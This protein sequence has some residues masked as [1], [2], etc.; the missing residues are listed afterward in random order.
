MQELSG[1]PGLSLA[2]NT[3][4]GP[5]G[6]RGRQRAVLRE[7]VYA[8]NL[9]LFV[10]ITENDVF[11]LK[12]LHDKQSMAVLSGWQHELAHIGGFSPVVV[13]GDIDAPDPINPEVTRAV[14]SIGIVT[15]HDG[16]SLAP[17]EIIAPPV[18]TD[19]AQPNFHNNYQDPEAFLAAGGRRGR[20]YVPLTDGTYFIN[21]WFATVEMI[22]KTVVPI[23]YVGVVVSYYGRLGTRP[24]GRGVPSR[25]TR[26][27]RRARR[28]GKCPG[29][30]QIRVQHVRRQHHPGADHELRAAL[31]HRPDRDRTAT[32][33]ACGRSTW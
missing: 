33:K 8:I 26:G 1:R 11:L 5:R 18:G 32:T 2:A 12:R 17:G 30:R 22:P 14:D 6:Q 13:G 21:R 3:P 16:P 10:V 9:A 27:R 25:R 15:V 23:G 29:P 4:D 24:L 7:G 28:V 31:D 19:A 20:Q